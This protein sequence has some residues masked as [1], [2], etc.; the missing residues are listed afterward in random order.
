MS[1]HDYAERE[2]AIAWPESD[3]MQDRI[4]RDILAV[5]DVFAEQGHSGASA[6]YAL[7]ALDRLLR[8]K[9]IA[10]L[11]GADDEW[12]QPSG[13][14]DMQQNKRCSSVFRRHFDNGT[15]YDIDGKVFSDDG[16]KTFYSCRESQIPVTFPYYPK[17]KPER[18][19][20]PQEETYYF[21]AVEIEQPDEKPRVLTPDELRDL[22][23]LS[24]V[25]I[26][27]W[28]GEYQAPLPTIFAGMK[29][30]DGTIVD[31]DGSIFSD[32]EGDMSKD[33][34]DGS[35]WRFW[36]AMP[37]EEQRKAEKWED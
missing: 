13:G 16:G 20:L 2:M 23:R 8:F 28:D 31:E 6:A 35:C 5:I 33:H 34:F 21:N 7:S 14:D 1:L 26:E 10:P 22:P 32:F 30:Y 29:C 3:P 19:I 15:A 9:P 4:K 27:C 12:R 36:N 17:E 25:F 18:V 24:I 37:T 11:T